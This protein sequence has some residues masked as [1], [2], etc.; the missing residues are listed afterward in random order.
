MRSERV[1]VALGVPTVW[2][3]LQQH[4]EAQGLA[5]AAELCLEQVVIG[6]AA[7]PRSQVERFERDFDTRVIHAW[8]MTEMSPL[9][10]FWAALPKHAGADLQAR[11]DLQ[12]KQGRALF[13]V[14]ISWSTRTAPSCHTT[15]ARPG[16][17]W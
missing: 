6:G 4:V 5:P 10:T 12:G 3:L 16:I 13:G 14:T 8:G 17:C 11:L 7:A 15:A 1:T 2:M 9:G